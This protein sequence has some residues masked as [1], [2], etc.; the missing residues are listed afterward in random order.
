MTH[1]KTSMKQH[2]IKLNSKPLSWSS[3]ASWTYNQEQ[4]AK[5][6]LEGIFEEES[7]EMKW[8]KAVG[9][10]LET[11]PAYLPQIPRHSKMEH[12]FKVM[13]GE[14]CLVGFADSFCDKTFKKLSEFKT[15]KKPWDQQRVD[16]H[17]QLTMYCLMNYITN[18]IKPE[19]MEITLV[20]MPTRDN[21]DF[22]ISFVE[23]I[24]KNIKIFKTKR[25]MFDIL[26]FASFIK[27]TY[28][29][30]CDY[31]LNYS[32]KKDLSTTDK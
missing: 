28:K 32:H 1:L 11:D 12:G 31:A 5:K 18:K 19:D 10:L 23:P 2:L 24:E 15:G 22:S 16:Q 21:S 4:W 9:K 25:T 3:I 29:E 26:T 17:G 30:M 8:G 14:I 7:S 6:Y 20:W 13:L 27:K